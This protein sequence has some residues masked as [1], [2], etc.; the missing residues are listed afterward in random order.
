MKSKVATKKDNFVANNDDV[1]QNKQPPTELMH[2]L[3]M[4]VRAQVDKEEM[5]Q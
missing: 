2:R 1:K 5:K 4:G 3:A